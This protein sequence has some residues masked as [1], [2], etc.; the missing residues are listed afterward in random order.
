MYVQFTHDSPLL[1]RAVS[2]VPDVSLDIEKLDASPTIPLR[3]IFR[4]HGVPFEEFEAGL[5]HD[6]TVA[7]FN[8]LADDQQQRLYCVVAAETIP[9]VEL[10]SRSIELQGVIVDATRNASGWTMGMLFPDRDAF[11]SFRRACEAADLTVSVESIHSGQ[12]DWSNDD[13]DLTPA[14][15]EILSR[16]VEVGYFDIPRETTLRGLGDEVGVSGQA[17]SERLR[18]GME[19]L[20]RD[21]L[22]DQLGDEQ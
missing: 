21:T 19:T 9:C 7:E 6:A 5:E 4:A 1:D 8:I 11:G 12:V 22:S 2:A 20:V 15:R 10:Y 17:A 3:I 18:R 13:A 16:A 14:Q